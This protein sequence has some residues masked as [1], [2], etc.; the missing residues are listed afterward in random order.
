MNNDLTDPNM[1]KVYY[2]DLI[3]A[4]TKH[5]FANALTAVEGLEDRDRAAWIEWAVDYLD[6]NGSKILA[7]EASEE[8][9][10]RC[11]RCAAFWH[12]NEIIE[13]RALRPE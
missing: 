6:E 11:V 10:E 13:G 1:H 2:G 12:A 3:F 7:R 4:M 9:T 5:D 8:V